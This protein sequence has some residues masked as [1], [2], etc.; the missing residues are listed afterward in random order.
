MVVATAPY[1]CHWLAKQSNSAGSLTGLQPLSVNQTSM[2]EKQRAI[3]W[4]QALIEPEQQAEA[5]YVVAGTDAGMLHV[6]VASGSGQHTWQPIAM[7]QQV[8]SGNAV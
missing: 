4:Q 3:P 2:L 6:W 5:V 1:S 7:P 8:I